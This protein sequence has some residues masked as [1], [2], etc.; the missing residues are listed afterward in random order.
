MT[1]AHL[2]IAAAAPSWEH[3]ADTARATPF[4]RPGWVYAWWDAFGGNGELQIATVGQGDEGALLPIVRQRGH[5]RSLT[6]WHSVTSGAIAT[7]SAA[8]A[9]LVSALL[10]DK[11]V[12]LTL[13]FVDADSALAGVFAPAAGEHGYRV[14]AR[15][16]EQPPYVR[17]DSDW[18]SYEQGLTANLRGDV[19]R[20]RRRLEEAGSLTLDIVDGSDRLDDL[21]Q[22][23]LRVE[24]SGWKDD[25]RTAIASRPETLRFYTDIA[26]WAAGRGWLRLAFLRLD[27]RA[28]AFHLDLVADD[29]LY[30]LKGGYDP[31]SER[32]SPG[33]VLHH[34]MLEHAFRSGM[35]RYEFLGAADP[36]KRRW[37]NGAREV[38]VLDAF[39]PSVAGRAAWLTH[40]RARPVAKRIAAPARAWWRH[41]PGRV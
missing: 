26:R 28:I 14:H 5:H 10:A 18:E 21:L 13:A 24:G 38:L 20:R 7:G 3:L 15:P 27:G 6:N 31:A 34:M 35:R 1:T 32:F 9:R 23:G 33:K 40:T 22:E 39:A 30:Q 41:R 11:P 19:R 17:I 36:H 37:A 29:V 8:A 12:T 16:L 2:R 4:D 25:A